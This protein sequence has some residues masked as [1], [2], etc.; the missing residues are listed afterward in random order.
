MRPKAS[1]RSMPLKIKKFVG[2]PDPYSQINDTEQA[3][4]ILRAS[5]ARSTYAKEDPREG[6]LF[7]TLFRA[8]QDFGALIDGGQ[9]QQAGF[10]STR[11]GAL[12]MLHITTPSVLE[13]NMF[14][15]VW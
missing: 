6:E 3:C 9:F 2:F 5:L 15:T 7:C 12:A 10:N 4:Q 1:P 14:S 13:V 11:R 8:E